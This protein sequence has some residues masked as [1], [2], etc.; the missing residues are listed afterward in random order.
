MPFLHRRQKAGLYDTNGRFARR[1]EE[2]RPYLLSIHASDILMNLGHDEARGSRES[3]SCAK[4]A[5]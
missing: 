5:K 4:F 1:S 2:R 3:V